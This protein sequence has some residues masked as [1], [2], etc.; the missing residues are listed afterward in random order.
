VGTSAVHVMSRGTLL[1]SKEA[2]FAFGLPSVVED[3]SPSSVFGA[4]S[5]VLTITGHEFQN[6]EQMVCR[7][8]G[9]T[10]TTATWR[11]ASQ[12]LCNP[13]FLGLGNV[14]V[15]VADN[16]FD[17]GTAFVT[18][19]VV[20]SPTILSVVPSIGWSTGGTQVVVLGTNFVTPE[21]ACLFGDVEIAC[22]RISR[23]MLKCI[24]PAHVVGKVS[25]SAMAQD[26]RRSFG[27]GPSFRYM[28]QWTAE[29]LVPSTGWTDGRTLVTLVGRRFAQIDG[30]SC[31]FGTAGTV[32][33]TLMTSSKV[34]CSTPSMSEGDVT[35]EVT[36][37]FEGFSSDSVVFCV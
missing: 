24:A 17:F 15:E 35:V 27:V 21:V 10:L 28:E 31:R 13:A 8:A 34:I 30:L 6:T 22:E 2:S 33:A 4:G 14:T 20:A 19:E 32:P 36:G 3:I 29:R 37:N 5:H 25:V 12:I 7:F 1:A 16:G 26:S 9:R 23:V 11:S 18:L